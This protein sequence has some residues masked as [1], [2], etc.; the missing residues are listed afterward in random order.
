L[1]KNPRQRFLDRTNPGGLTDPDASREL[2]EKV[3]RRT[4]A[5]PKDAV[6]LVPFA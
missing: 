1:L 6:I 2:S 4:C 5:S 3:R